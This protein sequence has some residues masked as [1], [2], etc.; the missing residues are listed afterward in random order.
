MAQRAA[1]SVYEYVD[2]EAYQK[3]AEESTIR[4]GSEALAI[5][6]EI[7][8]KYELGVRNLVF[9]EWSIDEYFTKELAAI[10][11]RK[12]KERVKVEARLANHK[13]GDPTF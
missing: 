11:D 4:V 7:R 6:H 9:D 8:T 5:A 1:A 10:E 13:D 12:E 2:A 3:A